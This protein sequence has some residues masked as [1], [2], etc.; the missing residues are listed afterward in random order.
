M[1]S[2]IKFTS[3]LLLLIAIL[4]GLAIA[5]GDDD[6]GG[7]GDGDADGDTDSDS[8]S[9]SDADG[10]PDGGDAV[11]QFGDPCDTVDDCNIPDEENVCHDFGQIGKAC[12]YTCDVDADCPEGSQGQKCNQQ[13]VCRP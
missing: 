13:G 1:K 11:G 6:G 5:C 3:V 4:S 12:T 8:D 10:G 2:K 7:S 9:D